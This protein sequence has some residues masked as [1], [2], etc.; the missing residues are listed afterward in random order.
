MIFTHWYIYFSNLLQ[1]WNFRTR[2]QSFQFSHGVTRKLHHVLYQVFCHLPLS[3]YTLLY[4]NKALCVSFWLVRIKI[5]E[6]LA[7]QEAWLIP[8]TFN[9]TEIMASG[10]GSKSSASCSNS[11][12][13][14]EFGVWKVVELFIE[15]C[16]FWNLQPVNENGTRLVLSAEHLF[17][18]CSPRNLPGI[19]IPEFEALYKSEL[20]H[21]Q[22]CYRYPFAIVF[23]CCLRFLRTV[24]QLSWRSVI[25]ASFEINWSQ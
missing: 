18:N 19:D 17:G 11:K 5:V 20:M 22:N 10:A 12:S 2:W 9:Q 8:T 24:T 3:H 25:H 13:R 15:H 7:L 1:T 14:T 21:G 16:F 4:S 23:K 6:H